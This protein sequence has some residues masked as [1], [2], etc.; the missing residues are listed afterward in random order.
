MV[1]AILPAQPLAAA[2]QFPSPACPAPFELHLPRT[3]PTTRAWDVV[4][5]DGPPALLGDATEGPGDRAPGKVV[6]PVYHLAERW[7]EPVSQILVG[8]PCSTELR[9]EVKQERPRLRQRI[10]RHRHRAI[11]QDDGVA[12]A[13]EE[14]IG[15]GSP[16]AELG[17]EFRAEFRAEPRAECRAGLGPAPGHPRSRAGTG[18]WADAADGH[19]HRGGHRRHLRAAKPWQ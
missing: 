13:L 16:C 10:G 18:G 9:L 11:V 3:T 1:D 4:L 14:D 5:H 19:G 8:N 15:R 7:I 6:G 12:D 17:A 2:L